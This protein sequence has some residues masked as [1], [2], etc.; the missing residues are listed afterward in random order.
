MKG[1]PLYWVCSALPLYSM[2]FIMLSTSSCVN[3]VSSYDRSCSV[4]PKACQ[5][6][7]AFL[8]VVEPM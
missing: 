8:G 3:G 6:R 4:Y 5:L 7:V 1:H 2:D